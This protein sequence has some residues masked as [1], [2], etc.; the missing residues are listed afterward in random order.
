MNEKLILEKSF[1]FEAHNEKAF[2]KLRDNQFARLTQGLI[3]EPFANALDQQP[4]DRPVRVTLRGGRSHSL[5]SFADDGAGLVRDNLEALHYI[6]KSSKHGERDLKIGRFGMGLVGAFNHKL[7]V[8]RVFITTRVCDKPARITLYCQAGSIPK[9]RVCWLDQPVTGFTLS[10]VFPK[11][12]HAIVQRELDTFFRDCIV[13]ATYNGQRIDHRPEDLIAREG[14][15]HGS[16]RSDLLYALVTAPT[17]GSGTHIKRDDMRIYLRR[18]LVEKTDSAYHAFRSGGDKMPQNCYSGPYLDNES[19][20]VDSQ[21]GEPTVGRDKLIRNAEFSQIHAAIRHARAAVLQQLLPLTTD[22]NASERQRNYAVGHGLANLSTLYSE[23]AQ[24]LQGKPLADEYTYLQPLLDTLIATSLFQ[25][26]ERDGRMS[27][28]DILDEKPPGGYVFYAREP[29]VFHEFQYDLTTPFVLREECLMMESLW[30]YHQRYPVNDSLKSII[31]QQDGLEMVSLDQ[32][33]WDDDKQ[34]ELICKGVLSRH[35]VRI[36]RDSSITNEQEAFLN[37]IK[38]LLNKPWFRNALG[39]FDPPARIRLLPIAEQESGKPWS[40]QVVAAVVGHDPRHRQLDIGLN[41]QSTAMKALARAGY[42]DPA[43]LPILCHELAHRK[44][45]L[46]DGG[47][48][49]VGHTRGFYYDRVRLE[50]SVLQSYVRH[51][52]GEETEAD[53]ACNPK[54]VV[55]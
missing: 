2:E 19:I 43:I 42:A 54:V 37:R 53:E 36:R 45:Q 17:E 15:L 47:E 9:W 34:C 26:Y 10:F 39:K 55:L 21:I 16:F 24:R 29:E 52:C 50:D 25:A 20:L 35:S 14:D 8:R 41:F 32:L 7:G 3:Q 49:L 18:M 28:R 11:S 6:G 48:G 46:D 27:I 5:L 31:N 22:P 4:P 1:L 12:L 51:L 40:G 23:L 30:G 33:V 38:Q 13:P 44:R